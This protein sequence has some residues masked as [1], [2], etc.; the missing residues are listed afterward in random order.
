MKV[1]FFT[2]SF[3]CPNL[4]NGEG[5]KAKEEGKERKREGTEKRGRRGGEG[6]ETG[7][8]TAGRRSCP[9]VRGVTGFLEG[10]PI[11]DCF[12][13]VLSSLELQGR[14]LAKLEVLVQLS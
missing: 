4:E 12:S 3:P 13:P 1:N 10:E 14:F 7:E 5:S 2:S 9:R 11:N 8:E 6:R